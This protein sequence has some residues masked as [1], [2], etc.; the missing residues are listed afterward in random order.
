MCYNTVTHQV[1]TDV[2]T[3][4][5]CDGYSA[6]L[7]QERYGAEKINEIYDLKNDGDTDADYEA[8]VRMYLQ[9]VWDAFGITAD[10][11]GTLQ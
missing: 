11:I 2:T 3:E 9:P 5:E 7:F 1:S 8:H 10:D 6:Q 4:T